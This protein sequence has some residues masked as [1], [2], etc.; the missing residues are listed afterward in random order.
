MWLGTVGWTAMLYAEK[1]LGSNI[2]LVFI[3]DYATLALLK[4][5]THK[6]GTILP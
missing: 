2:C 3:C 6:T 1:A 4:L 5:F